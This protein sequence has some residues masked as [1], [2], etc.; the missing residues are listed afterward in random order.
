MFVKNIFLSGKAGVIVVCKGFIHVVSW[1]L[2]F[3]TAH[4][5]AKMRPY[6]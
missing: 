1:N 5:T 3:E 4:L 6:I 2:T